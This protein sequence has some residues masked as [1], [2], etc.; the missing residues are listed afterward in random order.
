MRLRRVVRG[1]LVRG[2]LGGGR[3]RTAERP[4]GLRL[5]SLVRVGRDL[6]SGL[7][8]GGRR[9]PSVLR[10]RPCPRL[11]RTRAV[12]QRVLPGPGL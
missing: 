1:L 10:L 7:R 8:D 4:S 11:R 5:R 6:L 12:C 2:E 3:G 9:L